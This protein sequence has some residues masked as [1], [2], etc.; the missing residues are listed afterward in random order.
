MFIETS[1]KAGFNIKVKIDEFSKSPPYFWF[2]RT[3]FWIIM[4]VIYHTNLEK[5]GVILCCFYIEH[6]SFEVSNSYQLFLFL[7]HKFIFC[8]MFVSYFYRS[9]LCESKIAAFVS[10][11]CCSIAR[12]GNSIF[13]KTGRHGWCKF[14]TRRE[15][16][17]NRAARRRLLV[18]KKFYSQKRQYKSFHFGTKMGLAACAGGNVLSYLLGEGTNCSNGFDV[19][20]KNLLVIFV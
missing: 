9:I 6:P 15:F 11:D 4:S 1:A 12:D 14:E 10:K 17:P 18:L 8:D 16:I 7:F 13:Y 2:I 3:C 5:A 19:R 20:Y